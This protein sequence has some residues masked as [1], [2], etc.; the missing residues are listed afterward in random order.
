MNNNAVIEDIS[1]SSKILSKNDTI[2][3]TIF[4]LTAGILWGLSGICAQF[5][6]QQR[7]LTPE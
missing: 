2:K 4:A 7:D 1:N 6:F 3:G 5:L